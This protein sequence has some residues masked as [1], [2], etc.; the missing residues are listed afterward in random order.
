MSNEEI[1]KATESANFFY[2]LQEKPLQSREIFLKMFL[3]ACEKSGTVDMPI[4]RGSV[5]SVEN[6]RQRMRL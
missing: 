6:K 2:D 4:S 5:R 1:L 3:D